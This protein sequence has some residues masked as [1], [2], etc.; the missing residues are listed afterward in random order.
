MNVVHSENSRTILKGELE[1][2]NHILCQANRL[3]R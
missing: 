3:N 1:K 2:K